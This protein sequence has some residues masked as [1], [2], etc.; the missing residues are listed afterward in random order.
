M[1]TEGAF[2][3]LADDTRAAIVRTL[4]ERQ[5]DHP[6][7]PALAFAELRKAAG[8]RDSGNFNYHLGKLRGRFVAKREAAYRLTPQ[9]IRLAAL[10]ASG[11]DDVA[12]ES[13]QLD[14]DCPA[15]GEPLA[16]A[17]ADGLVSVACGNDHVLPQSFL[18]PA[19]ADRDPADLAAVASLVALQTAERVAAGVCPVCDGRVDPELRR[20]DRDHVP[21]TYTG[22]CEA[23]GVPMEVPAVMLA[24]R[25]P[26]V[27]SFLYERGVDVSEQSLWELPVWD[28]ET[29]AA[30]EGPLR[31]RVTVE[32]AGDERAVVAGPDADVEPVQSTE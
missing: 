23:C 9:G 10:V 11:F 6:R 1:A 7:D 31:V 30:S 14:A 27:V 12:V 32:V 26:S 21:F 13:T 18:W 20:T 28:A 19:G 4:A 22:T 25:H 24:A 15:C 5:R 8:V 29:T 2:E 17:Y 3:L 16:V